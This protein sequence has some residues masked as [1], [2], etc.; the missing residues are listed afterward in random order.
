MRSR[1]PVKNI[2]F[3]DY[4]FTGYVTCKAGAMG[5]RHSS[6]VSDDVKRQADSQTPIYK[7]ANLSG[8]GELIELMKEATKDN[9]YEEVSFCVSIH[10]SH[11]V[12]GLCS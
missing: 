3:T 10:L 11:T 12:G 2:N 6:D 8:G 5:N 9:N 1:P 4:T 7:F